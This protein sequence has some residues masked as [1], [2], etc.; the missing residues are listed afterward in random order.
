MLADSCIRLMSTYLKQDICGLGT[1]GVLPSDVDSNRI[2]DRLPIEVQ[3]ASVY[4]IQHLQKSGTQLYD[5]DQVH[6]FL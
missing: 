2:R 3:Y 5:N 4:W 6:Q 1:P